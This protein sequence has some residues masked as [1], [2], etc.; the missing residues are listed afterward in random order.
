VY[1]AARGLQW[2]SRRVKPGRIAV[3][4]HGMAFAKTVR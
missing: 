2:P 1:D 3:L 4:R